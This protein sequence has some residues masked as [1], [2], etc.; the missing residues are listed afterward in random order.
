[1]LAAVCVCD[2]T[3]P[4]PGSVPSGLFM[5][6]TVHFCRKLLCCS[7]PLAVKLSLTKHRPHVSTPTVSVKSSSSLLWCM[8]SLFVSFSVMTTLPYNSANHSHFRCC[9][10]FYSNAKC[11]P[12]CEDVCLPN[13]SPSVCF[14]SKWNKPGCWNALAGGPL[15]VLLAS[16]LRFS[17]QH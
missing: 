4:L 5:F 11:C 14:G 17:L 8:C 2:L 1:M 9:N 15:S 16:D 12:F 13:Y 6:V 7:H 10:L 3:A